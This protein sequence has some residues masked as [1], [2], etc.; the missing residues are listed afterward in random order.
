MYNKDKL[1][2]DHEERKKKNPVSKEYK[3]KNKSYCYSLDTGYAFWDSFSRY[4]YSQYAITKDTPIVIN[5]DGAPWIRKGV[6]YFEYAIY[7]YDRYHLKKW[8]KSAL[9]NRS[10]QERRKAYLAADDN[11]PVA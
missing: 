6:D 3:L 2:K 4:I 11:D 8:I 7:T 1:G 9:S 10:K 5:G